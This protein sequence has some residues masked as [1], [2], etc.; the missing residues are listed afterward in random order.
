MER[1]GLTVK[2]GEDLFRFYLLPDP[3]CELKKVTNSVLK[4]RSTLSIHRVSR[5][6]AKR[7]LAET[8]NLSGNTLENSIDHDRK[9]KDLKI[10]IHYRGT[11][12]RPEQQLCEIDYDQTD[13]L[14]IL[15]YR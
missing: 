10:E 12:L 14:L 4:T 3:F 9:F 8:L 1:N 5:Y 15:N 13:G 2:A 11:I 7:L 6:L